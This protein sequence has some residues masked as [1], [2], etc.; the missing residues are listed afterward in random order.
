[1]TQY[2]LQHFEVGKTYRSLSGVRRNI[3]IKEI[4]KRLSDGF[5][6]LVLQNDSRAILK[7][8][9]WEEVPE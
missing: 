1:M 9:Y 5:Y 4:G 7:P 6:E 2:T 3:T 8:L